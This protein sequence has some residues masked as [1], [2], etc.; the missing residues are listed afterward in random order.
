MGARMDIACVIDGRHRWIF[1]LDS[2]TRYYTESI[3]KFVDQRLSSLG[4]TRFSYQY[5]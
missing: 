3:H 5:R 4:N 2:V 1:M